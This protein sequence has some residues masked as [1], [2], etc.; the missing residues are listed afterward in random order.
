MQL[1]DIMSLQ[2]VASKVV[3]ADSSAARK[4]SCCSKQ[5]RSRSPAQCKGNQGK[6]R[7]HS[8]MSRTRSASQ[9]KRRGRTGGRHHS[10]P[11]R[12]STGTRE[13]QAKPNLWSAVG[14]GD[15][16]RVEN[17][18]THHDVS[19]VFWHEA[20]MHLRTRPRLYATRRFPQAVSGTSTGQGCKSRCRLYDVVADHTLRS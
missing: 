5:G 7:C 2:D 12:Q 18:L 3:S 1:S 20:I 9:G 15:E 13:R 8:R 6:G 11:W 14:A 16:A 10:R 17:L 4:T 19:L